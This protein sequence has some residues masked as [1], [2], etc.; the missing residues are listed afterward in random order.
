MLTA[1][2]ASA[3]LT[4]FG[5]TLF[6]QYIAFIEPASIM[7]V[8]NSVQFILLAIA[9]GAGTAFGPMIG[10][11]ILTPISL[12]LRGRLTGINGLHGFVL[13]MILLLVLL[14][15]PDG[16]LPQL[17]LLVIWLIRKTHKARKREA[18]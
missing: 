8:L 12:L 14:F 9:G 15:R 7:G 5:G 17:R 10:S 2:V 1:F 6:V 13:G 18:G 16:I 11:F 4:S 3:V